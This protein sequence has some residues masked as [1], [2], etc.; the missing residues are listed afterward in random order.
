VRLGGK[1]LHGEI[2]ANNAAKPSIIKN[3]Y[4]SCQKRWKSHRGAQKLSKKFPTTL[5]LLERA[6]IHCLNRARTAR[7]IRLRQIWR[8][9]MRTFNTSVA[10]LIIMIIASLASVSHA[11]QNKRNIYINGERMNARQMALV[12]HWN[13]GERVPNGSYWLKNN[14]EWGFENG[15]MEGVIGKCEAVKANQESRYIE[16]QI[17]EESGISIIQ[18]PVYQ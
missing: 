15:P 17:F 12:D 4:P 11:G 8:L 14:G 13:C 18:S 3:N 7:A 16:D 5:N 1:R 6:G 9:N 2:P 10:M